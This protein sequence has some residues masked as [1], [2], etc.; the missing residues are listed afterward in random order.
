MNA[1][2][3]LTV[4]VAGHV[5]HGKTTLVRHL[6]GV[7]TDR[8]KECKTA[9]SIASLLGCPVG[10]ALLER[11][12]G[13]LVR[14]GRLA[15]GKR[16]FATPAFLQRQAALREIVGRE[17][18][19]VLEECGIVPATLHGILDRFRGVRNQ[20]EIL[21]VLGFLVRQGDVVPLSNERYLSARA[22]DRIKERVRE[23]IDA[24]G[25]MTPR[26]CGDVLGYGRMIGLPIL[27]YLDSVGFTVRE[28]NERFLKG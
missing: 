13:E 24:H 25:S 11:L 4:G 1:G 15:A 26:D 17:V 6:A 19:A 2:K 5:D 23:R 7:D 27:E 20:D 14:E 28:G 8:M 18:M 10:P 16:G 9:A 3:Y 22:L 21:V 12:L